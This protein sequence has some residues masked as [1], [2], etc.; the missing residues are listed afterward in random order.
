[1]SKHHESLW[2]KILR[3]FMPAEGTH[4]HP[5]E[6][7]RTG[8]QP[9]LRDD[10][11]DWEEYEDWGDDYRDYDPRET[12]YDLVALDQHH[13]TPLTRPFLKAAA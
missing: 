5:E 3:F 12:R 6:K 7:S 8:E 11:G 1:M 4:A 2:V 10:Y 13:H 9:V